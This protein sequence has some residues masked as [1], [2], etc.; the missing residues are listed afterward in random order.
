MLWYGPSP[1]E[2]IIEDVGRHLRSVAREVLEASR[3]PGILP[4]QAAEAMAVA[5]LQRH[6]VAHNRE[7]TTR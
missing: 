1:V 5:T 4:R 7:R 6:G 2:R 3:V